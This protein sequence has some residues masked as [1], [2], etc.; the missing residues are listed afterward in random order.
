MMGMDGFSF[1]P[2]EHFSFIR[3]RFYTSK[4]LI[5]LPESLGPAGDLARW[6]CALC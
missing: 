3:F 4:S 6:G 2:L 5:L 1:G